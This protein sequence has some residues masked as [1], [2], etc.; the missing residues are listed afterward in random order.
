MTTDVVHHARVSERTWLCHPTQV[1]EMK[2]RLSYY[3]LGGR[4][5]LDVRLSLARLRT[6]KLLLLIPFV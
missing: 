4:L 2:A 3:R 6:I 5:A 1:I